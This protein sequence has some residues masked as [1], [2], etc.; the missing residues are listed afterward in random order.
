MSAAFLMALERVFRIARRRWPKMRAGF[1]FSLF[2]N[3]HRHLILKG[4][5]GKVRDIKWVKYSKFSEEKPNRLLQG[6][7]MHYSSYETR[8]LERE[9]SMAVPFAEKIM[10]LGYRALHW[11]IRMRPSRWL[12]R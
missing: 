8:D 10:H 6:S 7:L 9:S 3:P 5:V 2:G 1:Y 12:C 11:N 4:M